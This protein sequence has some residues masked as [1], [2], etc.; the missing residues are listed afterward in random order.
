MV[1]NKRFTISLRNG[2]SEKYREYPTGTLV[3]N[4]SRKNN[5]LLLQLSPMKTE[6]PVG[7]TSRINV[8][9]KVCST[10]I[11]MQLTVAMKE[12]RK[13]SWALS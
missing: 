8:E 5:Y 7:I 1:Y 11:N 13:A 10:F 4:M 3:C 6:L 9:F 2:L 12:R